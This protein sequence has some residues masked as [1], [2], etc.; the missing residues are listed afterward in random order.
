MGKGGE[1]KERGEIVRWRDS[2]MV[3]KHLLLLLLP[4]VPN[5]CMV[6]QNP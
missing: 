5:I 1:G 2:Y 3:K 6:P 4:L